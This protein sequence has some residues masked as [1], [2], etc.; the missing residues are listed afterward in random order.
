MASTFTT[1]PGRFDQTNMFGGK[2][3]LPVYLQFVPGVVVSTITS[4]DS[5]KW[6]KNDRN[7]NSI[8]AMPHISEKSNKKNCY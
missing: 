3:K 7:I 5:P 8:K 2:Q 4:E 6:N 1:F